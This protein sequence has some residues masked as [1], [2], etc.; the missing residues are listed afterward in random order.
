M[1]NRA[2][3]RCSLIKVSAFC[4]V[5]DTPSATSK[6]HIT[7]TLRPCPVPQ[8]ELFKIVDSKA[9]YSVQAIFCSKSASDIEATKLHLNSKPQACG[10]KH[11]DL[12]C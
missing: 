9:T 4:Q 10:V 5:S 6:A 3:G 11:Q 12:V 1:F 8:I 7:A 2:F